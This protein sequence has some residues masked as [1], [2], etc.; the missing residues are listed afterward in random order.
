MRKSRLKVNKRIASVTGR[1][2]KITN[3]LRV[4]LQQPIEKRAE[5]ELIFDTKS[6]PKRAATPSDPARIENKRVANSYISNDPL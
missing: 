3:R 5:L 6:F 4:I 2:K 1:S